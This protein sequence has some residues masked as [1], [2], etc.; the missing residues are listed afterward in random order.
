[1]GCNYMIAAPESDLYER[2]VGTRERSF[3]VGPG[4]RPLALGKFNP[5]E[6][7]RFS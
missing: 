7:A 1:M 3:A 4:T 5:C 6:L 2:S